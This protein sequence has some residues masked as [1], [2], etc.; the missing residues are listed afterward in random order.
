ML[1]PSA[2][3]QSTSSFVSQNVGAGEQKRAKKT[4]FTGIGIGLLV[5]C[6]AFSLVFFRGD[7]LAGI[8]SADAAVVQRGYEYLKV[9]HRKHY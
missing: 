5:G 8:F 1:I 3:M 4:M 2:L 7:L 9:S 6:F